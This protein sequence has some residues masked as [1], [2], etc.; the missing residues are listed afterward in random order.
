MN[1]MNQCK[2]QYKRESLEIVDQKHKDMFRGSSTQLYIPAFTEKNFHYSVHTGLPTQG[3]S[4][5]DLGNSN[6]EYITSFSNNTTSTQGT[7]QI[8]STLRGMG[9]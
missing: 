1:D 4:T 3:T 2:A 6:W 5:E 7:T 8:T 9:T